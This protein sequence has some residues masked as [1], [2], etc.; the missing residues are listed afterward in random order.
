[1]RVCIEQSVPV[2][3]F[4]LG[5]PEESW[6]ECLRK[7][8]VGVWIQAGS[9]AMAREAVNAG[10]DAVIAQGH[11]AGGSNCS[12]TG[13][14]TLVPAVVDAIDPVPVLAAGGIADGRGLAAALALGADAVWMGTRFLASREANAHAEYKRRI[15]LA[16]DAA[17][18]IT[19]VFHGA[20]H[21]RRP[22]RA[23]RNRVVD[24]WAE[25]QGNAEPPR[26]P[27]VIGR[28]EL[29]GRTLRVHEFSTLLPTPETQGD[30]ERMC[31]LAGESAAL[32]HDLRPAGEI[33]RTVMQE[34]TR[35]ITSRFGAPADLPTPER[36]L[37]LRRHN[38]L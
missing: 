17:T 22:V 28:T 12:V 19:T 7:A 1:V 20:E 33:I 29:G 2:V 23:L 9:V 32:V 13:I 14:M 35:V 21:L 6:I 16:N 4:H 3:S 37:F 34:C 5:I 15:L 38:P 27:C 26:P 8:G 25:S 30:F 11:E 31:L 36:R 10:A 24:A 18:A